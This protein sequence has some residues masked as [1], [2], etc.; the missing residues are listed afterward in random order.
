MH[1]VEE[2]YFPGEQSHKIRQRNLEL[3]TIDVSEKLYNQLSEILNS[4]N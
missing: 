4:V 1:G 2:I 3:G